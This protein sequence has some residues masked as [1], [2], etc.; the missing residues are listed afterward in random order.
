M[1]VK[2]LLVQ[3][4]LKVPIV[5]LA[6]ATML[7]LFHYYLT[8]DYEGDRRIFKDSI[9]WHFIDMNLVN[10]DDIRYLNARH[11]TRVWPGDKIDN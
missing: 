6:N 9:R 8:R 3:E 1:L 4:I 10:G 11:Q 7:L 2:A 5:F